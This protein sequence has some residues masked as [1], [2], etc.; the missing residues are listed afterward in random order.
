MTDCVFVND[1]VEEW[2]AVTF[3][4]FLRT[5]PTN[6]R[7]GFPDQQSRHHVLEEMPQRH[8]PPAASSTHEL[9]QVHEA[10]A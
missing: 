9:S 8:T 5:W 6:G 3:L 10:G 7:A 2:T 4:P 1:S